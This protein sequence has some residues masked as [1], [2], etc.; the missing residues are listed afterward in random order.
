MSVSST[1]HKPTLS[2]IKIRTA[3]EFLISVSK[4]NYEENKIRKYLLNKQKLTNYQVDEAFRIYRLNADQSVSRNIERSETPSADKKKPAEHTLIY[5]D[6]KMREA[7]QKL[8]KDFLLSEKSYCAILRSLWTEYCTKISDMA[9][10]NKFEMTHKNSKEMFQGIPRLLGFHERLYSD[11]MGGADIG[12]MFVRLFPF[13]KGYLEYMKS[14]HPLIEQF[15]EYAGDKAFQKCLKEIRRDSSYD[16]YDLIGLLLTPLSRMLTYRK[17]L[18]KLVKMADK[19]NRS[20]RYLDS[21]TRR[22][23]RVASYIE[24]YRSVIT[25]LHEIYRVQVWL[26]GKVNII[27]E[28]RRIVK[29]GV[30]TSI[31]KS[32]TARNKEYV[33]FLFNDILLWATKT[34]SFKNVL[35]VYSCEVRPEDGSSNL[36]RKFQLVSKREGMVKILHLAC[37]TPAQRDNWWNILKKTIAESKKVGD[38]ETIDLLQSMKY[39]DS[40]DEKGE[41]P[42]KTHRNLEAN[43]NNS[44]RNRA[45]ILVALTPPSSNRSEAND[46]KGTEYDY[47]ESQC[48]STQEFQGY[49]AFDDTSSLI[50]ESDFDKNSYQID[51]KNE[52]T[53][54]LLNPFRTYATSR[55]NKSKVEETKATCLSQL[56]EL[57]KPT[58]DR[59]SFVIER[60]P[61]SREESLANIS[62]EDTI[63]SPSFAKSYTIQRSRKRNVKASVNPLDKI[64]DLNESLPVAPRVLLSLRDLKGL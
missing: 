9:L 47:E 30:M 16:H 37:E 25:N 33:F 53:T 39:E 48:Y 55:G 21:A 50:S 11:L 51:I 10:R 60:A 38:E 22:I 32:W 3:I 14:L 19:T 7:G 20:Y 1:Y 12:R 57:N 56:T 24:K 23:G 45:K 61:S 49:D 15:G 59:S 35:T 46:E 26:G 4:K 5:L 54:D 28:Q 58:D 2:E 40:D 42:L 36:D 62:S 63:Q 29:R 17:F 6:P 18:R 64:G 41:G 27:V 34:G 44:V 43:G 13:F 8:I 52:S 31:S